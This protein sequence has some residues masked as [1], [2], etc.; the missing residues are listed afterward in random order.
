MRIV[1][2]VDPDARRVPVMFHAT[3]LTQSLWPDNTTV[4]LGCGAMAG[5]GEY[6]D[7]QQKF[8][9]LDFLGRYI[10]KLLQ[11]GIL[12]DVLKDLIMQRTDQF[13]LNF[14]PLA[15]RCCSMSQL[16]VNGDGGKGQATS[17]EGLYYSII[18]ALH[19]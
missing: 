15:V 8:G 10:I 12:Y 2:S 5:K 14:P 13:D 1:L 16:D 17:M 4:E 19:S 3:V 9:I 11:M 7:H 6:V 18:F